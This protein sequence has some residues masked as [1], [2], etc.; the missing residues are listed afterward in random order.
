LRE[1]LHEKEWTTKASK[2]HRE[3]KDY[4]GAISFKIMLAL[5]YEIT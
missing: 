5:M 3:G 4:G 1:K 2:C